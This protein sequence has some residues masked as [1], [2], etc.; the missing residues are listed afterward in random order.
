MGSEPWTLWYRGHEQ[1]V[2]SETSWEM[3]HGQQVLSE[4]SW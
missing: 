1:Q 4:T 3:G 2:L